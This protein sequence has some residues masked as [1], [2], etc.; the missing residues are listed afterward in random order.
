MHLSLQAAIRT[1]QSTQWFAS[2]LRFSLKQ[3]S[4]SPVPPG[5]V[6]FDSGFPQAAQYSTGLDFL[7]MFPPLLC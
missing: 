5:R 3:I 2:R 1:P 7:G 4:Q 6:H